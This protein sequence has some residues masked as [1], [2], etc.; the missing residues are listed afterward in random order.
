MSS[1]H[2]RL[3]RDI[4]GRTLSIG[5][6]TL[7]IDS[8]QNI[9]VKGNV[10]VQGALMGR[11][12]DTL[13]CEL[14]EK[15]RLASVCILVDGTTSCSGWFV[16]PDGWIGT[17]AH[18]VFLGDS[19]ADGIVDVADVCVTV[20][21][22]DNETFV[23]DPTSIIVDGAADFAMLKVSVTNQ[24]VLQWGDS[25]TDCIGSRCFVV[26][27]PLGMDAQSISDGVV[28]DNMYVSSATATEAMLVSAP[29]YPGNSGSPVINERCEVI[30]IISFGVPVAL[31]VCDRGTY[32]ATG[33]CTNT[34]DQ[35]A[36]NTLST[37][38]GGTSS[39][40][41][42]P[43]ANALI[44]QG[45]NYTS[46]GFL[47]FEPWY[48][49]DAANAKALGLPPSFALQGIR[50]NVNTGSPALM[51][52]SGP[53]LPQ[54]DQ[55]V[56]L[57]VDFTPVGSGTGRTHI[58]TVTWFKT[59]GQPV[60]L[61]WINAPSTTVLTTV[62]SLGCYPPAK[63]GINVSTLSATS[64][65]HVVPGLRLTSFMNPE[66]RAA[67]QLARAPNFTVR[68][69]SAWP[70]SEQLMRLSPAAYADGTSAPS[71]P[72][73]PNP[74]AISNAVSDTTSMGV[75]NDAGL[76]DFFW[77]WGQILDHDVDLSPAASPVEHLNITVPTGDA[78]F[79]PLSSGTVELPF[80]RSDY[81]PATGTSNAR[82]QLTFISSFIDASNVYGTNETRSSWLRTFVGG[83]LKTSGGGTMPPLND[84]TMD[85]A[86]SPLG[87]APFVVGDVRGNEQTFLLT[88]HT[89]WVKEH[90]TWAKRIAQIDATLSDEQLYQ[91]AR[92]MVESLMQHITWNEFLPELLGA[93]A[94]PAYTGYNA[95]VDTRIANEFSTAA[96]RL[97]HSLVSDTLWRLQPNGDPLPLGHLSLKE[98]FFAPHRFANEGGMEPLL[99]GAA[100]HVCQQL[101]AKVVPALRNFLFGPP[102]A[103][104]LDLIA[105]NIQRGRDHGIA[106]YNSVRVALGLGA[107]AS[108]AEITS[109]VELQAALDTVY[110][111]DIS[112]VDL[113]VGGLCEDHVAGSQLGETFQH[114]V[115]DQFVRLRD[116]DALWYERRL[117]D[118]G[119]G[120]LLQY[121][122]ATK[123]SHVICRNTSIGV[124]EI[125]ENVMKVPSS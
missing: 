118:V 73:R 99:R 79:D 43:V 4:I 85:N 14:Y 98:A 77:Q 106:D 8:K 80:E 84:G 40:I 19:L 104:G 89:L 96:F 29:T 16:T 66:A 18:C 82:E 36:I 91:R 114:I 74:R 111:G 97:G 67:M 3:G 32:N 81:D 101:D 115:L 35:L 102:G 122:R 120:Q 20:T 59:P 60:T 116:G 58:S 105:L 21:N 72:T 94:L 110:G 9:R 47:G 11:V 23:Y 34:Y 71:G 69:P 12:N 54:N 64:I 2:G 100:R 55:V 41:L 68:D 121:V 30:G 63:D 22:S 76:S 62:V 108:F 65:A 50:V 70:G 107:R 103:G 83:R 52:I 5:G 42:Q 33:E 51:P 15:A 56:V 87:E 109:D 61:S 86:V 88:M 75:E 112:L 117:A 37:Y 113:W 7:V 39:R 57:A 45:V 53:A 78:W 31:E 27:N 124:R 28:R 119:G 6:D 123:L 38:V 24:P 125:Q 26:G 13:A 92:V 93:Q 46:K 90:N 44:A 17:A 48:P 1:N 10:V 95:G 25:T 49:L